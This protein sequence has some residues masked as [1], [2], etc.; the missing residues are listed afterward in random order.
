MKINKEAIDFFSKENWFVSLGKA[1]IP[2]IVAFST[3]FFVTFFIIKVFDF[4]PEIKFIKNWLNV[5]NEGF[6]ILLDY[7]KNANACPKLIIIIRIFLHTF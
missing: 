4:L 5:P 2:A 3:G 6:I 1:F 7:I